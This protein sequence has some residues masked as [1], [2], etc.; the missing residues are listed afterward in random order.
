MYQ[1]DSRCK[2]NAFSSFVFL[3]TASGFQAKIS[4]D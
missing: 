1:G 2:K 3:K 4:G